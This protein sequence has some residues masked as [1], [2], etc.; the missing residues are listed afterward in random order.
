M[1]RRTT[2]VPAVGGRRGIVRDVIAG[3]TTGIANMPDAM[4]SAILAGVNPITG[5]YALMI[6]TPVAAV[7]RSRGSQGSWP[8]DPR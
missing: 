6:G 5:L 3:L 1:T 7:V 4:A 2:T 8:P